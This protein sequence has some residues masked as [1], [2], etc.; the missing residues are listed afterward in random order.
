MTTKDDTAA[1]TAAA[2]LDRQAPRDLHVAGSE[3]SARDLAAIM[4]RLTGRRYGLMRIMSLRTLE[5]VIAAVRR[6]FPQKDAVFPAWQ[7]MQYLHAMFSGRAPSA[8]TD[9]QRYPG[10]SWTPVEALLKP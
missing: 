10:I 7:G 8:G 1:V 9:N 2:A 5:R 3:V 6:V 4:T